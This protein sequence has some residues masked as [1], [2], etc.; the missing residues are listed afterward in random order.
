MELVNHSRR[1]NKA[2]ALFEPADVQVGG[3]RPWDIRIHNDRLL[4]RILR[5]GSLGFGEAYM[6]GWWDCDHIDQL[7]ERLLRANLYRICHRT[8][9]FLLIAL[10]AKLFNLQAYQRAFIIGEHHYDIGNNLFAAMLDPAMQYSCG[11]WKAAS[12]LEQAQ[13]DKLELICRKLQ[14]EPG[15]RLLDIGCG[16]GGLA[17]YAASNYGVTVTGITVSREQAQLAK[18]R[19]QGLPVNIELI[20]Y[21]DLKGEYDRIVSVGMFEHVGPKN[22]PDYFRIA[23]NLLVPGGLF[24]LHTIG[25]QHRRA[26][27]DP[28]IHRYIFPN[29]ILP[30]ANL[31]AESISPWFVMEDWHSFGTDY[32]KTL[33]AWYERFHRAWPELEGEQ[34]D[35]TFKRMFDYYLLA[36]AGSFRARHI[37]L[38]QLVL[39]KGGVKGGYR[40][41]R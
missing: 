41:P 15:M 17:H 37:H 27:I 12:S 25:S 38:W 11:Y 32:D 14:L 16:W 29:G 10:S 34:Y 22:Y 21:R 13:Q 1:L 9:R 2:Q 31:L 5:D 7:I 39:A 30:P 23:Y 24:L 26:T 40:A 8:P 6:E 4:R 33:M 19:C 20:D 3:Q 28:W 18:E 35:A 36:C